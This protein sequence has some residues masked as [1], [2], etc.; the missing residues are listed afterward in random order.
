MRKQATTFTLDGNDIRFVKKI[1]VEC[2]DD[3]SAT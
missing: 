2:G 1:A 3:R